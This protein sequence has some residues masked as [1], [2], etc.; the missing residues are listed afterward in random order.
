MINPDVDQGSDTSPTAMQVDSAETLRDKA[1]VN[2]DPRAG[3]THASLPVAYRLKPGDTTRTVLQ[4]IT[5]TAEEAI[6][7]AEEKV[8]I[9]QTAYETVRESFSHSRL[10]ITHPCPCMR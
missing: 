8:S 4:H 9:A 1:T 10:C 6:R 2:D 5:Q 7:T 3:S